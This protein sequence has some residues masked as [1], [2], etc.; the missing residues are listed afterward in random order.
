MVLCFPLDY[1]TLDFYKA[2]VAPFCRLLAWH[3]SP[4]KT[5][6]F[7]DCLV[8]VPERVPHSFVVSQGSIL[9]GSGHSWS[10]PVYIIGGHFP[11]GFPQEED[12]VPADGLPHSAH[13][14]AVHVNQ[15]IPPHWIHDLAAGGG[16]VVADVGVG[17]DQANEVA[18]DLQMHDQNIQGQQG[19][20]WDAWNAVAENQ[21]VLGM[22]Q[23]PDQPQFS[24]SLTGSSANYFR[25]TG[26][27]VHLSMEQILRN[28]AGSA[29]SSSEEVTS[30]PFSERIEPM[31]GRILIPGNVFA[32]LQANHVPTNL[33]LL[34]K[35]RSWDLAFASQYSALEEDLNKAIV[36]VKPVLHA[37][38]LQVWAHVSDMLP[39]DV[40]PQISDMDMQPAASCSIDVSLPESQQFSQR[41]V[42]L[43]PSAELYPP[44]TQPSEET[45]VPRAKKNLISSF[46]VA[47][48][49]S[50]CE[51]PP[52]PPKTVVSLPTVLSKNASAPLIA[53]SVRISPRLSQPDGFQHIQ[54]TPKKIRSVPR[55]AATSSSEPMT[56]I[57]AMPDLQGQDSGPI[58]MEMLQTWGVECGVPPEVIS[59][60]AL[61]NTGNE[62]DA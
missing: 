29:S 51:L 58:P 40:G 35:K 42:M 4:N 57:A 17:H 44:E 19:N 50:T 1:Q 10:A 45:S 18:Q 34:G 41:N 53:T 6:S 26:P 2:A 30:Q 54:Y 12:P 14:H 52:R 38:I 62:D 36:P 15:N 39:S 24:M 47:S 43:H 61:T 49:T 13:G 20:D 31:N 11:D 56:T 59:K 28:N 7:L 16:E 46:D 9:G 3:E 60:D 48:S 32:S 27:S 33:L 22:P 25:G 37:I 23:H 5:K 8:L 21:P 55:S